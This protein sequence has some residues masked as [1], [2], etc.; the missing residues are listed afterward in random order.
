MIC[1]SYEITASSGVAEYAITDGEV[2]LPTV[3]QAGQLCVQIMAADSGS[4]IT[5]IGFEHKDTTEVTITFS[6]D[7]EKWNEILPVVSGLQYTVVCM[8]LRS[9]YIVCV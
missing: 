2:W 8:A 1:Y 3:N 4:V 9:M 5:S 7:G 6:M